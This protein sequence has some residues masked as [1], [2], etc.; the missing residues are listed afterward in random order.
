MAPNPHFQ[1][2]LN[3]RD[4]SEQIRFDSPGFLANVTSQARLN[5]RDVS[6]Q[7]RFDSPGFLANVTSQARLNIRDV[8]EQIRFDSP[9]L[10]RQFTLHLIKVQFQLRIHWSYRLTNQPPRFRIQSRFIARQYPKGQ[11][12]SS[13]KS[14]D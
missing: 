11:N 4:M 3:V 9:G 10:G 7:I 13:A 8:S 6:E 5:V 12:S 2:T 14:A 1:R